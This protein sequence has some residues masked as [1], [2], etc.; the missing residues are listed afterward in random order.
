MRLGRRRGPETWSGASH[1]YCAL[2]H[3]E[4]ERLSL[5]LI[6][7][8]ELN[9]PSGGQDLSATP[10]TLEVYADGVAAL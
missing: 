1:Q 8:Y 4:G 7:C 2:S 10:G 3:G 5:S 6:I 9:V